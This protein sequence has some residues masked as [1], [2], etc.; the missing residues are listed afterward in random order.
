MAPEVV[1]PHCV[2]RRS[3][4]CFEGTSKEV[5]EH[6]ERHEEGPAQEAVDW[7]VDQGFR[8]I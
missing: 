2:W 8:M 6:D 7:L 1:V 5:K 3:R 4:A